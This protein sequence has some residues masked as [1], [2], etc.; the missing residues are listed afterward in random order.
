[1]PKRV[2]DKFDLEANEES[3]VRGAPWFV[4]LGASTIKSAVGVRMPKQPLNVA[5]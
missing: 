1:M 3:A 2:L 4:R 5:Q